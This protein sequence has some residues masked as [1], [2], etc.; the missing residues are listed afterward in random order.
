MSGAAGWRLVYDDGC[1]FCRWA[2]GWVLRWDRDRRVVPVPISDP[3]AAGLLPHLDAEARG[4][5]WHLVDPAGSPA[6]A[7][8]AAPLL[9]RLLPGGGPVASVFERVPGVVESAYRFVAGHR[10]AFG[11]PVGARAVARA[12]ALISARRQ[13][14]V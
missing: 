1:R 7:G 5:S 3:A 4:A 8:A 14:P 2:L 12:D 9:L 6:S 11:R 10:S 13:D